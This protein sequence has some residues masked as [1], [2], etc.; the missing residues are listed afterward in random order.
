[1]KN[2]NIFPR[3]GCCVERQLSTANIAFTQ[4]GILAVAKGEKDQLN[5]NPKE[6]G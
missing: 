2:K 5:V 3:F 1:M 4:G 6:R